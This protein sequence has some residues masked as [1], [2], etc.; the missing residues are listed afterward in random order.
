MP[1]RSD[2]GV[3]RHVLRLERRHPHAPPGQRPAQ[4]GHDPALP[5]I[6]GRPA[7]HERPAA[8]RRPDPRTHRVTASHAPTSRASP[9]SSGTA[10]RTWPG[11]PKLVQSRTRTPWR[12]SRARA[13]AA[14][15]STRTSTKL[16]SDGSTPGARRSSAARRAGVGR[17]PGRQVGPG[18]QV[19][20]DRGGEAV[21]RPP[22]LAPGQPGDAGGIGVHIADPEA[23]AGEDLG[24]R[25]DG[26]HRPS[27]ADVAPRPPSGGQRVEGLV[28]DGGVLV[29]RRQPPGGVVG[30]GPD[31]RRSRVIGR[32][33]HLAEVP[34]IERELHRTGHRRP[35]QIAGHEGDRLGAAVGQQHP[36]GLRAEG[37]RHGFRGGAG[38]R[39]A[40]EAV[41]PAGGQ[42]TDVGRLRVETGGEVEDLGRFA[43]EGRRHGRGIP[44]MRPRR[45]DRRP[46]GPPGPSAP[47]PAGRSPATACEYPTGVPEGRGAAPRH[48]GS[49]GRGRSRIRRS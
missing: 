30:V 21:E 41:E 6:A 43:P 13:A 7:D 5:G 49:R 48:A 25:S 12:A 44:A 42:G 3:E 19:G 4:P 20:D 16:A 36:V 39:I 34:G 10:T 33:D 9:A 47:P 24:Q 46:P 8:Q 15:S 26:H 2:E 35:A 11:S 28:P 37:R 1:A 14:P 40:A 31:Q 27:G 18:Q 17:R 23:R 32:V 38:V 29:G 22:G 45:G